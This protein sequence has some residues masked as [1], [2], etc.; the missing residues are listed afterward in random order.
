MP[1]YNPARYRFHQLEVR[2]VVKV[3]GQIRVDDVRVT[4]S[5]QVMHLLN[6]AERIALGP[7][8]VL[9]GRQICFDDRS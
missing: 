1:V 9:L 5:Q 7:I 4:R 3:R 6:R 2:N 8:R